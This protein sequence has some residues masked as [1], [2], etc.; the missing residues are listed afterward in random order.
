[1]D[2]RAI[3]LITILFLLPISGVSAQPSLLLEVTQK[4]FEAKPGETISVPVTLS[5]I[6]NETAENI[7]IYISGPLVEGLLYSQDVIKKLEPGKK[8]E[9]TLPIY[10]ENPKAG[11]YDLKVVA[12]VGAVLIEV[13][14][15]LRILTKVSYSIDIDVKD[16]YLF[17]EDVAVTLKVSSSSNGVIFG[18]VS[19]EIYREN[20]SIAEKSVHNIFLY[21]E[22]PKNKWEYVIFLPKPGVGKYTILVRTNFGGLSKTITKSFEVYQRKLRYETKFEKG[23]IYVRVLDEGGNGVEGIPVTIEG[24]ELKTNSY[25]I[26]FVEAKEP[27]TYHITLNLDGK[28]V[29]TFVEV[30]KLFM[31]YEQRNE[32]LLVYV[33]DSAGKGIGNVTIEAIGPIGK[34]YS[35][36]DENGTA[37][38]D[39]NETGFGSISLKAES[40][41]YLGAEAIVTVKEPKKPETETPTQTT[42]TPINQTTP[43]PPVKP[44]DYG[45]LPLIL[46]LSAIIFGSTSYLALFKPLK[47]EEQLDKY[48]FVKVRAPRLREL[49]NFRY[50]KA[51][52]AVDAR[53][54][55]GKVAIEDGKVIWEIDKL[56]PGEEA[57]LQVIL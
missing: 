37:V 33:R 13:P 46:V 29:E 23:I 3:V 35:I 34:T 47:F 28:I 12:R 53:A 11:V 56:E 21:P 39:L 41:R 43:I 24:T 32:T 31:A 20:V 17:G 14:I 16:R 38:I 6:G 1:M 30:K 10:V 4:S 52:N 48:Y 27:G 42:S 8:V 5:N 25:G 2:K 49:R 54:T 55:K 18:D 45:N 57:F 51:I 7:T 19:Y 36:T 50:E 22:Y 15:S 9:K 40:D 44:K 26:A